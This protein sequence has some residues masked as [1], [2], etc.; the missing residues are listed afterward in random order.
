MRHY[1]MV[2]GL[3]SSMNNVR[4]C[5]KMTEVICNSTH[6]KIKPPK[7]LG[8]VATACHRTPLLLLLPDI[9]PTP[10]FKQKLRM[11]HHHNE[12]H[13]LCFSLL[14]LPLLLKIL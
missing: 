3:M 7:I 5:Q 10:P 9:L 2:N 14:M 13:L 11:Y 1:S 6:V 12:C 4:T 8:T